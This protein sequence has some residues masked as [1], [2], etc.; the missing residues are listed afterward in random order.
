M[1]RLIAAITL[2]MVVGFGSTAHAAY[3][4]I[5]GY[6]K[7][8]QHSGG[9]CDTDTHDCTGARYPESQFGTAQPV[10]N[11]KVYIRD[12]DDDVIGTCTTSTMGYYSCYWYRSTMPTFVRAYFH[13]EDED[14]RYKVVQPNSA[15]YYWRS[16]A[17]YVSNGE[18]R[19]IGTI[20][21]PKMGLASIY[22]GARR[23][24]WDALHNS[25]LMRSVFD[26]ITIRAYD[27]SCSGSS[28]NVACASG[29]LVRIPNTGKAYQTFVVAHE[30]GHVAD[31]VANPYSH[32]PGSYCYPNTGSGCSH[33]ID[34]TEWRGHALV[35]GMAT[36]FASAAWYQSSADQP[37][38]CFF[39][40]GACLDEVRQEVETKE[41]CSGEVG[42]QENNSTRYLWDIFDPGDDLDANLHDIVDGH[43]AI[44]HGYN[45]GEIQSYRGSDG[46]GVDNWDSFHQWEWNSN[47]ES[48]QGFSEASELYFWNCLNYF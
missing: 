28:D 25:G 13:F 29:K 36:Y 9:Y 18:N 15:R 47:F 38:S 45:W 30:L 23:T 6:Y 42:R 48:S 24:Y 5:R 4:Y 39:T 46:T 32:A 8:Q 37:M 41:T 1:N 35:E 21:M 20:T 40:S 16:S 44:P 27:T 12:Q 19:Y 31:Y 22:D 7:F 2:M 34:S 14:L 43:H 33:N 26:G 17:Q 11:G 10:E 3:G